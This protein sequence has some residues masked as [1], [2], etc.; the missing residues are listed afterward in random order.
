[1]AHVESRE[2]PADIRPT[3]AAVMGIFHDVFI[4]IPVDKLV[5]QHRIKRSYGEDNDQDWERPL[6]KPQRP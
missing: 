3:K 4:V 6:Q 1:M 5:L 2:H